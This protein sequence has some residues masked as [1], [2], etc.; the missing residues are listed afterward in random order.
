MWIPLGKY[1]QISGEA[2]VVGSLTGHDQNLIHCVNWK[3]PLVL[4]K[5]IS[6]R[7]PVNMHGNVAYHVYLSLAIVVH[8]SAW[9]KKSCPKSV[10]IGKMKPIHP[11]PVPTG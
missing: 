5:I 11:R 4:L 1:Q 3:V 7:K 9:W 6:S 8:V 10:S 2:V